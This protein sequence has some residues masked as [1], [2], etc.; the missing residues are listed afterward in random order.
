[1]Q[2]VTHMHTQREISNACLYADLVVPTIPTIPAVS[3]APAP[4]PSACMMLTNMFNP[5]NEEH[6]DWE[7]DIRDDVL[8]ACMEFGKVFHV[9]VDSLSQ[10]RA[11]PRCNALA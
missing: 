8:E 6:S 9:Y 2:V 4:V 1:M 11:E 10:V 7:V 5:N 3:Q